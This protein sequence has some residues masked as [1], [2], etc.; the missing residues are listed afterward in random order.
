MAPVP[1]SSRPMQR[2]GLSSLA[3][4]IVSVILIRVEPRVVLEAFDRYL[5]KCDLRLEG[6]V[7]G[8]T[9]LNLLGVVARP[10]KD[11]DILYPPLPEAVVDAARA[12]ARELSRHGQVLQDDWLNNG[13]AQL[14][15]QLP[16]QWQERL[17]S[18]FMGSHIHLHCLG[19]DDLLRA[20]LFALCDRGIDLGDCVALA[21]TAAE[22]AAIMPWLE[23]QDLNPDWP[24]HVRATVADLGR[25]LG[26]AL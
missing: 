13:P 14:A 15:D 3:S 11:C 9:A 18:V 5:G 8:G 16:A 12:F 20:K 1:L 22:L 25:K 7:I 6:V 26:H 17:Q 19:R 24:A 2:K 21:P 23:Y 4:S 10:T